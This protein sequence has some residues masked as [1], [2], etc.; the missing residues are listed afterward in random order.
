MQREVVPV[1]LDPVIAVVQERLG[2][3]GA[4]DAH[5][6]A[7][8]KPV[9]HAGGQGIAAGGALDVEP[10]FAVAQQEQGGAAGHQAAGAPHIVPV[11]G[12]F[13]R[14]AAGSD[15]VAPAKAAIFAGVIARIVGDDHG[16]LIAV[17][18]LEPAGGGEG[19]AGQF[20]GMAPRGDI[21]GPAGSGFAV[22]KRDIASVSGG[23]LGQLAGVEPVID[24]GPAEVTIH[25]MGAIVHGSSPCSQ[26]GE[27][28]EEAGGHCVMSLALKHRFADEV[29]F[30][31]FS[32]RIISEFVVLL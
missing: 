27:G 8:G 5:A 3:G 6:V 21:D 25:D 4:Q 2:D 26:H 13:Q 29:Q 9:G 20:R 28:G 12:D 30:V 15:D 19:S 17:N 24:A 23:A 10:L 22:G 1:H 16:E 7:I 32:L 31:V 11:Q 14:D 18:G